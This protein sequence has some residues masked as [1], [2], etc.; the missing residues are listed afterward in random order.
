MNNLFSQKYIFISDKKN[1]KDVFEEVYNILLKDNLVKEQFLKELL[2]REKNYPTGID[3][4]PINSQLLNIAIPHTESEFVNQTLIV[5]IKLEHPIEFKN[6]M[7]TDNTLKVNFI[8]MILN[9][10]KEEQ[11]SILA[12]IMEFLS[13]TPLETLQSL[14]SQKTTQQIYTLL[15]ANF[16]PI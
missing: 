15:T 11:A 9:N 16:K 2:E 12:S 10:L 14:F 6:M 3:L 5:P 8:F 7:S 1:Q 4:S 13:T